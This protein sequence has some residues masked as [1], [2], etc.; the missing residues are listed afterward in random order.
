MY[1]VFSRIID[2]P[3][4]KGPAYAR[5]VLI[6]YAQNLKPLMNVYADV[7]NGLVVYY[8]V[9][10]FIYIYI[11][12]ILSVKALKSLSPRCSTVR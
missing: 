5:F 6:A 11:L 9:C 3:D 12:C 7:S 4:T 10:I 1:V 2:Y 8:I